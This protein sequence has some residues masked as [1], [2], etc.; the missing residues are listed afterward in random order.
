MAMTDH[1]TS[2]FAGPLS[3]AHLISPAR[4]RAQ[5]LD[6]RRSN[7]VYGW[8]NNDQAAATAVAAAA[9]RRRA[10]E[11]VALEKK[12]SETRRRHAEELARLSQVSSMAA[13][14]DASSSTHRSSKSMS[15]TGPVLATRRRLFGRR[16]ARLWVEDCSDLGG[17]RV[18]AMDEATGLRIHTDIPDEVLSMMLE[19]FRCARSQAEVPTG[20]K[21]AFC[22]DDGVDIDIFLNALLDVV[23]VVGPRSPSGTMEIY[24]PNV[25]SACCPGGSDFAASQAQ[26]WASSVGSTLSDGKASGHFYCRGADQHTA[27]T[28]SAPTKLLSE[29][30]EKGTSRGPPLSAWSSQT[31]YQAAPPMA[32][33]PSGSR[34]APGATRARGTPSLRRGGPDGGGSYTAQRPA[35]ARM[36]TAWDT[37][38]DECAHVADVAAPGAN[39]L[40][41][42][43]YTAQ[44]LPSGG[45]QS[46][47]RLLCRPATA[48]V[49]SSCKSSQRRPPARPQ[50]APH[51]ARR[52]QS[53]RPRGRDQAEG[54]VEWRPTPP[55]AQQDATRRRRARPTSAKATKH[56][57]VVD[58]GLD[59]I[60]YE[61]VE[62]EPEA[63]EQ[64]EAAIA[65]YRNDTTAPVAPARSGTGGCGSCASSS[66]GGSLSSRSQSRSRHCGA[67]PGGTKSHC[68]SE[69][70][71]ERRSQSADRD[72]RELGGNEA[73]VTRATTRSISS[74]PGTLGDFAQSRPSSAG[75]RSEEVSICA[76]EDACA[77]KLSA[78]SG[79]ADLEEDVLN[80]VSAEAPVPI[81]SEMPPADGSRPP[82][83]T[84]TRE[85]IA[86]SFPPPMPRP[87]NAGSEALSRVD[88]VASPADGS[89]LPETLSPSKPPMPVP[90]REPLAAPP[91]G[92]VPRRDPMAG[93]APVAVR[94][95]PHEEFY[96]EQHVR[97]QPEAWH[98][99][100]SPTFQSHRSAGRDGTSCAA[101]MFSYTGPAAGACHRNGNPIGGAQTA[102]FGDNSSSSR[103]A[104][105]VNSPGSGS[106]ALG[107]GPRAS[108]PPPAPRFARGI[109]VT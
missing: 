40:S 32:P 64:W 35:T 10:A 93:H 73:G 16:A 68:H 78:T 66:R 107:S 92:S 62:I 4:L 67:A 95:E 109:V 13:S 25:F 91:A 77:A 88:A 38:R 102:I 36:A 21:E 85:F 27:A 48:T 56:R 98:C 49:A 105:A 59:S 29:E 19:K 52:P 82:V 71:A 30:S 47:A 5:V 8:C 103:A 86:A 87:S 50:S 61:D 37:C 100:G 33:A 7:E 99:R 6:S 80:E 97:S 96:F 58:D 12:L 54:V 34:P 90:S 3:P 57:R 2:S 76:P 26:H 41:P 55:L 46:G 94:G 20:L 1:M 104:E 15:G 108:S 79:D 28:E 44:A 23:Y 72:L 31:E 39:A 60:I 81:Q 53:A 75:A 17:A 83:A 42:A 69:H 101:T 45:R 89:T 24:L 22:N 74:A 9:E 70:S 18:H 84:P 11:I 106:S 43:G 63:S 51:G 14:P 65:G